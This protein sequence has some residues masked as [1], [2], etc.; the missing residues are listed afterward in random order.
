MRWPLAL[1][2]SVGLML[3]AP[4][5]AAAAPDCATQAKVRVLLDGR[6]VL[7]SIAVDERGRVFFTDATSGELLK[8]RL[9][10]GPPKVIADGIEGT[11][12][13][14]FHRSGDVLVGFGNTLQQASDGTENP[15]AG[16]LSVDPRTGASEIFVDGL[17]MANGVTRGP[18][19]AI[20]ASNDFRTGIDRVRR[21]GEVQ[22]EWASITSPNGLVV[23]R[24]GEYLFANQ[25]FTSAA[26]QRIPL[27]DPGS[28]QTWFAADP[29]DAGAGFDGIARDGRD[30]LYVAANGAGQIWRI[31]RPGSA[32]VLAERVPFP[33]G[34]SD[35]AFARGHGIPR[36]SLLVTT[37]GGE[38]LELRRAR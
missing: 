16:L 22:L 9:G 4:A 12:G 38:L 14:V 35:V 34:P 6:G 3:A 19:G 10:G 32:C 33:D 37:F 23:D 8:L 29:A 11:G 36:R 13:I 18:R 31:D 27:D 5:V 2:A 24:A 25:T 28:P 30:R 15:E 7:E 20:Y 1:I 21:D 17:Q 26:I